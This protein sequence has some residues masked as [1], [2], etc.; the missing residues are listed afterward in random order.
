MKKAIKAVCVL[1]TGICTFIFTMCA[2]INNRLPDNFTVY[3]N[4]SFSITNYH[5]LS[6]DNNCEKD[7]CFNRNYGANSV[8]GKLMLMNIIPVKDINLHTQKKKY[9]IPCGN[10][11]GIKFYTKGAVIINCSDIQCGSKSIN[12]GSNCGLREG[13]TIIKIN[14]ED[15]LSCKDVTTAVQQ[16]EGN[17]ISLTFTRD[18]NTENTVITPVQTTDDNEYR[19]G[20]WIRDSCAG[21]GT[22]TFYDPDSGCFASLG[23]GIC[24]NDTASLLPLDKAVITNAKISSITKGSDG[25]TGSING[26]FA[27]D[28]SLGYALINDDTG[29]YGVLNSPAQMFDPVEIANIQ[30]VKKG[31]AQ[32]LCTLDDDGAKYYDIEITHVDYDETNKTKNLQITATDKRLLAKT[33]GIIQGMS[34]SPILQ[35]GKLIGAVTHVL[36]TNSSK[37]YGIFAQNMYTEMENCSMEESF[38]TVL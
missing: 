20:L 34:G 33:G 15:V 22:M 27:D 37:G 14:G 10:I 23:H 25:I 17:P 2:E 3:E 28:T 38:I 32:I 9:V 21:L 29:L 30:D 24:D 12:P 4:D 11:F 18:G 7:L 1:L 6:F 16:S 5:S 36:V 19:I 35:N 13:D 26:Y 8:N 31:H